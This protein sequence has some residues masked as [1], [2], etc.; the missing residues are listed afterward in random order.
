MLFSLG[1][2]IYRYS[3]VKSENKPI[4][5]SY[6][7]EKMSEEDSINFDLDVQKKLNISWTTYYG[8]LGHFS[9]YLFD[10]K[11]FL[12]CRNLS[13]EKVNL[14]D[15]F[16]LTKS[17]NKVDLYY[18]YALEELDLFK[19]KICANREHRRNL[20]FIY[21]GKITNA[22][23]RNKDTLHIHGFFTNISFG[24]FNS[25]VNEGLYLS[26]ETFF[27][28]Q[29]ELDILLINKNNGLNLYVIY[30]KNIKITDGITFE[31]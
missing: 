22:S 16:K 15:N 13:S 11:Y 9:Y 1:K 19:Y 24:K 2:S 17:K 14:I 28:K 3:K 7:E 29:I 20:N 30:S 10:K 12:V 23:T 6:Y 25:Y 8:N 31:L 21:D 27:K 18:S 26:D 5:K 4:Q